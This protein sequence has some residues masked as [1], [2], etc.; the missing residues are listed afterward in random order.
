MRCLHCDAP[1]PEIANQICISCAAD[2]SFGRNLFAEYRY[3]A[4]GELIVEG[5]EH[6]SERTKDVWDGILILGALV[7]D[8]AFGLYRRRLRLAGNGLRY[9]DT[10]ETFNTE[11]GDVA[12]GDA[13]QRPMYATFIKGCACRLSRRKLHEE[14][15]ICVDC[16]RVWMPTET[17]EAFYPEDATPDP[18]CNCE[19]VRL[20]KA[21]LQCINCKQIWNASAWAFRASKYPDLRIPQSLSAVSRIATSVRQLVAQ[22]ELDYAFLQHTWQRLRARSERL[23]GE[24]A[25]RNVDHELERLKQ[26]FA[27]NED[28]VLLAHTDQAILLLR[29]NLERL[30]SLFQYEGNKAIEARLQFV[31]DLYQKHAN[32]DIDI[33]TPLLPS[34]EVAVCD[35]T[36]ETEQQKD[37]VATVNVWFMPLVHAHTPE[38][39]T[40]EPIVGTMVV[41]TMNGTELLAACTKVMANEAA[42]TKARQIAAELKER[43]SPYEIVPDQDP[44]DLSKLIEATTPDPLPKLESI[45]PPS[46]VLFA[47]VEPGTILRLGDYWFDARIQGRFLEEHLRPVVAS[48]GKLAPTRPTREQ[49]EVDEAEKKV[50]RKPSVSLFWR[51]LTGAVKNGLSPDHYIEHVAYCASAGLS[52]DD[53]SPV[54]GEQTVA[55]MWPRKVTRD[56]LAEVLKAL[57]KSVGVDVR[58][59]MVD[60]KLNV[61]HL[62]LVGPNGNELAVAVPLPS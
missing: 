43:I 44:P 16:G 13:V 45:K 7:P 48:V 26:R 50:P 42:S 10:G 14:R 30:D 51:P 58:S 60:Q 11:K 41:R 24:A 49:D 5:V 46:D 61:L 34:G 20:H 28:L 54:E 21:Q 53:I 59:V 15:T 18:T 38:K 3:L 19:N 57:Y 32:I 1:N 35:K 23:L 39:R 12:I 8:S 29:Q 6:R 40:S 25:T 22:Q 9:L 31:R 47:E 4:P 55:V 33:T 37:D 17:P 62:L 2:A 56:N 36:E 52:I 27:P